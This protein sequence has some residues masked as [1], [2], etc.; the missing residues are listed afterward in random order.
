MRAI[1][2]RTVSRVDPPEQ[3]PP[4]RETL[5][6]GPPRTRLLDG[7]TPAWRH[8]GVIL[9][10]FAFG[11][12]SGGGAVW[13]NDRPPKEVGA[14]SPPAATAG[15]EVR[16]VLSG[17]VASRPSD[18]SGTVGAAP[19]RVDGVLLHG[20]GSGSATV[21]RIHRP[22]NSLAIRVPALPVRLA[23]EH[24]SERIRLQILPRDCE[25]ATQWT[26][27]AQPFTLTW[28]DDHGDVHV[29]VGGDYD[30][31]MAL[32]LIRYRDAVCGNPGTR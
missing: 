32:A 15:T 11:V 30:P 21:T 12:I 2:E 16:L 31:S 13:W 20:S 1:E 22:G 29:D 9:A 8:R 3:L 25:L 18:R 5:Q 24:S 23:V 10:A 6:G 4:Q 27:S 19:L 28:K 14:P 17:V 26:P 7:L